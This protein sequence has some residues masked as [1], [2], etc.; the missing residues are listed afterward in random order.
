MKRS[1]CSEEHKAKGNFESGEVPTITFLPFTLLQHTNSKRARTRARAVHDR[2]LNARPCAMRT[3]GAVAFSAHLTNTDSDIFQTHLG[4]F[5]M[6]SSGE[7]KHVN[8]PQK[9]PKVPICLWNLIQ[10]CT[11]PQ[12]FFLFSC[13]L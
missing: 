1:G 13:A 11:K 2:D 7:K 3:S 8:Y 9:D 4:L 6:G 10:T 5:H 12:N